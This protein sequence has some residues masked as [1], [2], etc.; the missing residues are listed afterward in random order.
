[1]AEQHETL[2]LE[3]L[4][5]EKPFLVK[6]TTMVVVPSQD[7]DCGVMAGMAPLLCALRAGVVCLFD[8]KLDAVERYFVPSGTAWITREKTVLL[9]PEIV[10]LE[11]IDLHT[12]KEE[13]RTLEVQE[14]NEERSGGGMQDVD[15]ARRLEVLRQKYYSVS[16][17][18]YA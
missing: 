16:N 1:M 14:K 18:P 6:Q 15:T 8:D 3:I 10:E 12:T 5:P 17:I 4:T 11:R 7:G 2:S 13:I 9:V